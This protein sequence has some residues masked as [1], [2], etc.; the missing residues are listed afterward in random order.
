MKTISDETR[1]NIISLV[2]D[3]LSSRQVAKQLGVSNATVSRVRACARPNVQTNPGGRPTKLSQQDK[4]QVVRL[5][6]S[7]R[8][9]TAV[10]VARALLDDAGTEVSSDTVRRALQKAGLK[11]AVKQKKPRLVPRHIQRRLEFAQRYE[12]WTVEDWKRVVWSDETKI[13]RLGSDGREWVWKKPG[14][15]LKEQHVK[16]T[17]KFGG[18]NLMMWGCMTAQ[19]VGFACRIEGRMDAELYCS[20]LQDELLQTV[21]YYG[22]NRD[23]L[24]FQQD[25]DPKHTSR[26][27]SKWFEDNGV[28]V[29]EWPAQSPDLNPIE[30]LWEHLKRQLNKY[31][32]EPSGIF[33]LWE[34]VEAEWNQIPVQV[35]LD[36]IESIPR[37]V[38]AVLAARGG[39]TKY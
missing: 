10:Q 28:E 3:G 33:E 11:A 22:L 25:N 23:Q 7:G 27:A 39:Y 32:T 24:I 1:S 6:T 18:G 19:G 13:N 34:R 17:L 15:A 37:R 29:L 8:A 31:E 5:V 16:G 4:R 12:H 36:L 20:I 26:L 38:A 30:H 9:D 2:D 21:E 35:C 14:T